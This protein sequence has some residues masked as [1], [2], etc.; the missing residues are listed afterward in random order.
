MNDIPVIDIREL[1]HH[2][3]QAEPDSLDSAV[4]IENAMQQS[5]FFYVSGFTLDTTVVKQIQTVQH[6][7]FGL[8]LDIKNQSAVNT[9][10]RGY[11]AS[12]YEV[13]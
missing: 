6:A 9:D 2:L 4:E 12:G 13:R 3:E 1:L 11:L 8:P 10:N 5:G 7:F